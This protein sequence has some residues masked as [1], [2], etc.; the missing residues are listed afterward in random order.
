MT[1]CGI[2]MKNIVLLIIDSM[3]YSHM[4][5]YP[6]LTPYINE[7]KSTG[8]YF[9]NMYSQAPYT[10]AATMN[11]Y[12][13]QNVL[14]YGGYIRRFKD[15]K[16]TIFEAFKEKGYTTY[17]NYFQP[18]CYPSSLRRGIDFPFYDV[19]FDLGALWS[20]RLYMYSSLLSKGKLTDEDYRMLINILDDNFTEWIKFNQALINKAATV[21]LI[22]DNSLDYDPVSTLTQVEQEYEKY[23]SNKRAYIVELLKEKRKHRLFQI[24]PYT[25]NNKIKNK[26]FVKE[27]QEK[28]SQ[29]FDELC[30]KNEGLNK[31]NCKGSFVGSRKK[32][33]EFL[34]HPSINS[35]KNFA[36]ALSLSL[37]VYKDLDLFE[38]IAD[39]Y[40]T[41]K[42]AP[43]MK[44]HID[45]YINWE[46]TREM[47][48]P[49]FACIH[50]DDIHNPEMFFTYDSV[51]MDLI[52]AEFKDAKDVVDHLPSDYYGNITHD[53]SLRYIDS[54]IRY[55]YEQLQSKG[56]ADNTIVL[57]CADHGFSFAGNPLRDS[58]VVNM[59]LENYN[60]PCIITGAPGNRKIDK[61]CSSKDI[62]V[63]LTYLADGKIP[64]EFNG[65]N[66]LLD[67]YEYGHVFIEYCGGG[68][69]DLKRRE[70]KIG[71]FN[72]KWFVASE[73]KL[74]TEL[75]EENVSEIYDL[76]AD[77]LQLHNLKHKA[78]SVSEV[79]ELIAAINSRKR[80]IAL[81]MN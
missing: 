28:Y 29:F 39:N 49:S 64:D 76:N 81:N 67:C 9:E 18:Q 72:K 58:A 43:S 32:F 27:V 42:N 15:A 73:L 48:A 53:L 22:W 68:C 19:G 21:N 61:L 54:K 6:F 52:D 56:L 65:K 25:Q 24:S 3:N 45:H 17:Y 70:L 1:E 71:C 37:N 59:Y 74:E 63:L 57:I 10:E 20:Y 79:A 31:T 41:F 2:T 12:C 30:A 77:P 78:Y 11:I 80:E 47:Q 69:P 36:K 13:G 4:K 33:L 75:T 60:I 44:R 50:V 62:S 34:M 16:K 40:E 66:V 7:L 46:T 35:L 8:I 51:D 5:K 14:D 23:N 26:S 38:R 55:F